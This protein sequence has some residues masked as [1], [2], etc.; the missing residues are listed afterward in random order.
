VPTNTARD[1]SFQHIEIKVTRPDLVV[2]A[3]KGYYAT[4]SD[5]Q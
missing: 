3:R 1:G 2:Q 5:V 4:R